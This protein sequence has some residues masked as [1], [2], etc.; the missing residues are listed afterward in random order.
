MQSL[1]PLLVAPC[2][3]AAAH[4]QA[5]AVVPV[6]RAGREVR[7]GA[8]RRRPLH[9]LPSAHAGDGAGKE[10]HGRRM[11][12][13]PLDQL[14]A[15]I[16]VQTPSSYCAPNVSLSFALW[17]QPVE[18]Q[19]GEKLETNWVGVNKLFFPDLFHTSITFLI[20]VGPHCSQ[21]ECKDKVMEITWHSDCVF[22]NI[23]NK[24]SQKFEDEWCRT[25][26][27]GK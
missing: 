22:Q 16:T 20:R 6:W 27:N 21:R 4:N 14:V 3:W 23:S 11:P 10:G 17:W 12:Q 9:P 25:P 2:R 8:R 13:P 24:E 1:T 19:H 18:Q 5:E 26:V 7:L 15:T